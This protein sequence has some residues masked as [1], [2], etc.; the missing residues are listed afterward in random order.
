LKL[1]LIY[2]GKKSFQ[3]LG[4]WV[5]VVRSCEPRSGQFAGQTMTLIKGAQG[6][7][8]G[9]AGDLAARRNRLRMGR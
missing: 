7:K 9:I 3:A 6:Q 2:K 5:F 1:F 8:T 4:G